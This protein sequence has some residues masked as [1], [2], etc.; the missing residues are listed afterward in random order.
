LGAIRELQLEAIRELQLGAIKKLQLEAIRQEENDMFSVD[1]CQY[2]TKVPKDI[3]YVKILI[4]I[5]T[6]EREFLNFE[7]EIIVST[8]KT[9]IMCS[10][11]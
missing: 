9:M 8:K 6:H 7:T 10:Q 1:G 11:T 2:H 3:L 4:F 5:N